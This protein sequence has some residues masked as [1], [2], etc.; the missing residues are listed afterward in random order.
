MSTMVSQITS[1]T[2]V[3]S[4]VYSGADQRKHQRSVSL[5]SVRGIHLWPMNSPHKWPVTR[6]I[7]PFWW[8]HYDPSQWEERKCA[9]CS[10]RVWCKAISNYY[11][12][13]YYFKKQ[14]VFHCNHRHDNGSQDHL[15]VLWPNCIIWVISLGWV[16][17]GETTIS[18]EHFH[19]IIMPFIY[20]HPWAALSWTLNTLLNKW[21]ANGRVKCSYNF[22]QKVLMNENRLTPGAHLTNVGWLQS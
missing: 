22:A 6:K 17:F 4:A 20:Q 5:A 7:F 15:A 9:W 13:Q 19:F 21:C 2:I 16:Y 3:Y 10:T 14:S 11:F 8:R 12:N 18:S 1:L